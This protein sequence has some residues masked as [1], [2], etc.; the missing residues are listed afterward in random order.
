MKTKRFS[1]REF[2]RLSSAVAGVAVLAGCQTAIP[3]SGD[4]SEPGLEEVTIQVQSGW[5]TG[6][7][8]DI[9][10][11]SIELF[12][13]KHPNII[14]DMIRVGVTPEDT[15]T[16]IAGG[17]APDTY[18]RYIGG[19]AELMARG[20]MFPLDDLI[21]DADDFDPD[22]YL[23]PQWDNGKWDGVTYGIPCLEGGA[24]PAISWHKHLIEDI[25]G[26][27]EVGPSSWPELLDWSRKL[28]QYDDAGNLTQAGYDPKDAYG[29]TVIAWPVV[30]DANYISDDKKTFQFDSENWVQGLESIAELWTD[31][32]VEQ[33]QAFSQEW[34]YWTGY[35]SSGFNNAKRAMI[36]NGNWMP[37]AM[38]NVVDVTGVE[39]ESIGHGF[40]PNLNE[41]LKAI[42][43]GTGH[44]LFMPNSTDTPHENF[45]FMTH[46]TSVEVGL[47]EY[48]IR[49]AA[50]WS[51]PLLEAID[52]SL[53][54]GLEWFFNAPLEA[55]RLWSP[56]DFLTPVQSQVENLW[57]RAI[58]ETMFGAKS[59]EDALV[60]INTEL[61]QSLD[62]YWV[63]QG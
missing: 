50:M 28:N 19:F 49:G 63:A 5:C 42:D 40:H 22:I 7:N 2:L 8:C 27:P 62:E 59:A 30:F 26:D 53:V 21:A 12:N 4:Q 33:M 1:R 47:I 16:S 23:G 15:M 18:H 46:M 13:E 10:T 57:Q 39:L 51:K 52:L 17:T 48:E 54:P 61:Q 55:D 45:K 14:V 6:D 3:Q 20:V 58:E 24:M 43:F 11:P 44:T 25:G 41:G 56:S 37:G 35:E 36:M 31:A 9:W 60:D 29:F 38:R 34:G 32:G